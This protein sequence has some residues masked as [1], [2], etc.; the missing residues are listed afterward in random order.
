MKTKVLLSVLAVFLMLTSFSQNT[1][2]YFSFTAVDSEAYVPLD[3]IKI[4]NGTQGEDTTLYW[5][6]TVLSVFY[7]GIHGIS[8]EGNAFQ[9]FRNYPNPVTNQTNVSLYVPERDVVNISVTDLTG[10][11]ILAFGETLD[12]GLHSF[13]FSPGPGT[14][15][16]LAARW[17]GISH[18]IKILH[19]D[20][21]SY[22]QCRLDYLG[23]KGSSP[24]LR[25]AGVIQNFTFN[26]GDALLC[27]GY[28]AG[29]QSGITDSPDASGSY[30]FQFATNIPCP[31]IPTV[32]YEGQ[33]YNT[34]QIFSQCWIKEN[35]NAG[36]M[37]PGTQEMADNGIL[38]KYCHS[39]VSDSCTKYGGLYQ[40]GEM[41]QYD[42]LEG[43]QG[44]CPPGWHLPTDEEWKVLEG[45]VDSQYGIGNGIWDLSG[46]RGFDAGKNLKTT[47]GWT[48]NGNG[49]DM[50]GFSA[51][52]GSYRILPGTFDLTG[53]EG[54]WWTSSA[55]DASRAWYVNI[56]FFSPKIGKWDDMWSLKEYGF[57]ARC[58]K[59]L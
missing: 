19:P 48:N 26:A 55:V 30:T 20:N 44:I 37:V 53:N 3:S 35:M 18:G 21:H 14:L 58:I 29:L 5:P 56:H 13:S 47:T 38:E 36:T 15:Y 45:S 2:F 17:R 23:C 31:G 10:K 8:G 42:T 59:D 54:V 6:D 16:F 46:L 24:G 27:I 57:S 39:N 34:I 32:I 4:M 9:L 22:G 33:V 40:W 41:M 25:T 12:Q 11:L 7:V 50:F 43:S 1:P 52:P 49:T 51:M 28:A